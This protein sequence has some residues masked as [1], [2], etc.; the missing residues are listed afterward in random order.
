MALF[1]I[2]FGLVVGSFLNAVLCRWH[3]GDS[4]ASGRSL[5]PHCGHRLVARDLIPLL[6]FIWLFGRC[7]FCGQKISWQYPAIEALTAGIFVLLYLKFGSSLE[8]AIAMFFASSLIVIAVFDFKHYLILDKVLLPVGAAAIIW[9][10]FGDS[11]V[12]GLVSGLGLA[13]FFGL[14][15]VLSRG[16]W[17]G[18]G[19]VKLGFVLG[20]I[21][22]WPLSLCMLMLAYFSGAVVGILLMAL[23]KKQMSSRLPFG[24]FLAFSA[25]I[26]MLWGDKIVAWYSGLIGL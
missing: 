15:Y 16:R 23:G 3:S 9:N 21:L 4:I 5:C 13:L 25:I 22:L 11:L 1:V 10:F 12:P 19:D 6:S 26:T 2:I 24:S 18:L 8:L 20:N 7:R 14:Q 17:I